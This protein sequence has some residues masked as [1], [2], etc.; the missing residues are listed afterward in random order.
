M[1]AVLVRIGSDSAYG[2]WQAPVDP[3]SGA[4]VY[5][6]IPESKK[7][8][9]SEENRRYG[10]ELM[11][12]L[13]EF[14]AAHKID[15][16]SGINL[17]TGFSQTLLH[18]DPDFDYLT[19]GDNG[20]SRG[21]RIKHLNNGDLLVFYAAL[22][23][24]RPCTERLIY[25]IVGLYVVEE[26]IPASAV[27]PRRRAENAHTRKAKMCKDDIVVRAK[28]GCSGRLE[29]AIPIG[30]FNNRA[31]RVRPDLLDQWG[32]LS[33]K[34]GYI[35]RSAVPPLFTQAH[36]FLKWFMKQDIALI[37]RNN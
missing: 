28:R 11:P 36:R 33:V 35:Q 34:A 1:Q 17:P 4:F 29:R 27:E 2:G 8:V 9:I 10:S 21:A 20:S 32:G 37:E 31:Y 22:R 30:Y 16:G 18:Y 7:S 26:V 15:C 6:P 13:Q 14:C 25:A 24:I 19:Y 3:A 12:K 23:P 5:V